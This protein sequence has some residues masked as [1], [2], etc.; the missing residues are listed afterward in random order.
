MK[1]TFFV[2]L[3]FLLAFSAFAN[4]HGESER[5]YPNGEPETV[6]LE[7]T[8]AFNDYGMPVIEQDG[9]KYELHVSAFFSEIPEV[10]EGDVIRVEGFLVPFHTSWR[11]AGFKRVMVIKGTINGEAF[12]LPEFPYAN[13]SGQGRGQGSMHGRKM[14]L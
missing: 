12:E 8:L 13:R 5:P 7:G 14:N 11:K 3:T 2:L 10:E 6:I 4:G 9:E 1:K